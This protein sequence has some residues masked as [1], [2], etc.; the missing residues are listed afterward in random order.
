MMDGGQLLERTYELVRGAVELLDETLLDRQ[1]PCDQWNVGALV[2]H[3][4]GAIDMFTSAAG[5]IPVASEHCSALAR[6]DAAVGSNMGAWHDISDNATVALPFGT[7][8]APAAQAI[9]QLD[10]LVHGWDLAA[11][12]GVPFPIPDDIAE[13]ALATARMSVPP[14]RG[15]VFATEVIPPTEGT[16]DRL[17]AFTG[18]DPAAWPGAVWL[19]GSLITVKAA[20]DVATGRPSMVEIWER[21]GSGPPTHVH[22]AHDELWYVLD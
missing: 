4:V 5:G 1:T 19:G 18:R 6:F 16:A 7:F 3:L 14:S 9:N 21:E 13:A 15:H 22:D 10:S 11:A 2:D 20:G 12:L 8:P 17:I